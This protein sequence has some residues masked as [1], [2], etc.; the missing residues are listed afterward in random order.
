LRVQIPE[1]VK[2]EKEY[3]TQKGLKVEVFNGT[4]MNFVEEIKNN[5]DKVLIYINMEEI[6]INRTDVPFYKLEQNGIVIIPDKL[7]TEEIRKERWIDSRI[8]KDGKY[9]IEDILI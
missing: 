4:R 2:E 8:K 3:Y 9:T 1:R 5:P 6:E 7:L